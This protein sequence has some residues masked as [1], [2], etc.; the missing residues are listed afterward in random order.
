MRTPIKCLNRLN[1][2]LTV[3]AI[4]SGCT[5]EDSC[6]SGSWIS[7]S[8]VPEDFGQA[9]CKSIISSEGIEDKITGISIFIYNDGRLTDSGHFE[10]DFSGMSFSLTSEES[11]D[12][13]A[14]VNMGDMRQS[15]PSDISSMSPEL[16]TWDIPSLQSVDRNGI[17]MSGVLKGFKA[18]TDTPVIPLK[19]LFAKVTAE[20]TF[21]YE[22]A[23]VNSVKILNLN[24]RLKPFGHSTA[25]S[26]SHIM[27]EGVNEA[28]A[29]TYVFYIP[30]NMQGQIGSAS[31]PHE[32]NPDLD[33]DINAIKDVL[34]YMEVEVSLDGQ[35]GRTGTITYRSYLGNNATRNF[36]ITGN[37]RYNWKVTY[38][39]DNLQYDDWKTDTGDMSSEATL[40]FEAHPCW[41]NE[42][43]IIL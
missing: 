1:A 7:F 12:I 5:L 22:G 8:C 24:G 33:P 26:A 9:A 15:M 25:S 3:S 41:D 37:C 36:D 16:I 43:D 32:K 39:E 4:L 40:S 30:E 6:M 27:S 29:G 11:Y 38:L 35:G 20:I 34:T 14:L 31:Q 2:V 28:K 18:G 13:F 23:E 42:G 17:P 21:G 10:N 19:R